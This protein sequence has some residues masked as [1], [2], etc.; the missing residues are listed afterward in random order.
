MANETFAWLI[1]FKEIEREYR[2]TRLATDHLLQSLQTGAVNLEGDLNSRH[3]SGLGAPRRDLHRQPVFRVRARPEAVPARA[4]TEED[5]A[6]RGTAHQ[7]SGS[8]LGIAGD[9]L[10]NAH[11]V[12]R[13][14]NK[15]VH[16][17]TE[18]TESFTVRLA[19]RHLCIFFDRLRTAW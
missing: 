4:E 14:R 18:E 12:R 8:T 16:H 10:Q 11:K 1:R 3:Q 9:P 15:L 6:L 17:L 7:P 2:A 19:T 5:P 13:H